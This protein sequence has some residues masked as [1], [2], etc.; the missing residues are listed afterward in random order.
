MSTARVLWAF[1]L[2]D[3]RIAA[4]YRLE[5]LVHAAGVLTLTFTFFFVALMLE[6]VES[7]IPALRKYGGSY[8]GFALVGLAFSSYLDVALRAFSRA[9]RNAQLTGTF[10]AMLAT[11]AP[12]WTVVAGSGLY[13]LGWTSFRVG[14]FF[15]LGSFV[16]RL[17]LEGA[18]WTAA[19]AVLVLT[20]A[21]TLVLGLFAAG[22]VVRF[23]QG[24]PVTAG[25]AGLSWLFSGVVY[26]REILP[27]E[28]QN[29]AYALPMTHS[30]EA[31]R[32]ALLSG[33]PLEGLSGS[34]MYLAAFFGLGFPLAWLW[35][36]RCVRAAKRGGSLAHY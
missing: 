15:L 13:S 27:D 28:V 29:F 5:F 3:L 20:V 9:L 11:R 4:S 7:Q 34:L 24:D 10:Q 32:L 1:L 2:R 33:V 12:L 8:F 6:S 25:I 19:L 17:P 35:F 22:F 31:M 26:P 23:K 36:A 18:R 16:F 21:A 14:L 30:L